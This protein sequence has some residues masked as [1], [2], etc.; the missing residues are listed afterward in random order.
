MHDHETLMALTANIVAAYVSNNSIPA[1]DVP[2]SI[3]TV[4]GAIASIARSETLNQ[5]PEQLPPVSIRASIK[6]DYLVCLEDGKRL[7]MLKRHLMVHYG[8]TPAAYRKKWNLPADYPMVAPNYA[9]RRREIA[10][11]IGLGKNGRGGRKKAPS[12]A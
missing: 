10:T 11:Q 4:Y 9:E 2:G 6:P 12:V 8:L 7:M 1:A 3:A 5:E